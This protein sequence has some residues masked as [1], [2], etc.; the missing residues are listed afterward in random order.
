MGEITNRGNNRILTVGSV[1]LTGC[2]GTGG[3]ERSID[4]KGGRSQSNVQIYNVGTQGASIPITKQQ[5][6]EYVGFQDLMT[7][8]GYRLVNEDGTYSIGDTG[9]EYEIRIN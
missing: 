1:I 8:L 4:K 9:K 2:A 6:E 3:Q 7:V 5:D